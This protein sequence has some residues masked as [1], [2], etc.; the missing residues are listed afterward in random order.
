[1]ARLL[2]PQTELLLA[3][4]FFVSQASSPALRERLAAAGRAVELSA[5]T[6]P[7]WRSLALA[8]QR[9]AEAPSTHRHLVLDS[10]RDVLAVVDPPAQ[11]VA[12]AASWQDR[13]DLR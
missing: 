4:N 2:E 1:M 5:T 9:A 3:A 7:A 6:E 11:R 13:A 10:I 8:A 12:G